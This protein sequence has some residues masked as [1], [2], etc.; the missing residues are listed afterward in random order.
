M[1]GP[2]IGARGLE[3]EQLIGLY[4]TLRD[5]EV[6]RSLGLAGRLRRLGRFR[7]QGILFD[8]GP[9]PA[10]APGDAVVHGE[11]FEIVD[12]TAFAIMDDFEEF[13]PADPAR[14]AYIREIWPMD[15]PDVRCWVY[16]YNRPVRGLPRV[17]GGDW[18]ARRKRR[19]P[20]QP[21]APIRNN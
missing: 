5:P 8:L 19:R 9:Y 17:L 10:L 4:G 1:S 15:D 7:L 12:R 13:S 20:R 11:L 21:D 3:A 2:V 6:R 16:R 18:L 14:S